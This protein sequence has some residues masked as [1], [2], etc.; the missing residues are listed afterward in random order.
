VSV[1]SGPSAWLLDDGRAGHWRQVRALADF[2]PLRAIPVP[3]NLKLPWRWFAPYRLPFGQAAHSGLLVA[4]AGPPGVIIAC[5]RRSA[6]AARWIQHHF[7]G[8]PK[9]VQI[10]DCGLPPDRFTWVIAPS[11][12]ELEG[13]N[14]ISTVGSLN[15]V[16]A[17]WLSA[18]VDP[19]GPCATA[20][21]PRGVLLLGGPSGNFAFTRRWFRSA[22][23]GLCDPGFGGS[24]T[25]VESPRTPGWVAA[26]VQAIPTNPAPLHRMPWTPQDPEAAERRLGAALACADFVL[27]T[28]DSVNL[29][30]EACASGK[31]V[32]L[33]GVE[34]ARGKMARFCR[35]LMD[36]GFAKAVEPGKTDIE[37]IPTT[38]CLRET[39]DVARRLMVSGLL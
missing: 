33:L 35:Q 25:I 26:E 7:A 24:L 34:R 28:A 13:D 36:S 2:L 6:L 20:P 3:V 39:E 9:T 23:A 11:H 27:V 17:A 4:D 31:P 14:V 15:P 22:L 16:T 8:R 21:K 38:R 10:L 29:A 1:N 32:G 12:D 5:G 19:A 37:A 18:A 30:S